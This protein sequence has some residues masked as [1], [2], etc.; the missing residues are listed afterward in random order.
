MLESAQ[1]DLGTDLLDQ[2]LAVQM[3]GRPAASGC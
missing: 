2:Q 1:G 3:S